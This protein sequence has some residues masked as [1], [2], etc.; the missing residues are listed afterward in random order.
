MGLREGTLLFHKLTILLRKVPLSE[1]FAIFIIFLVL[2]FP[3]QKSF[4]FTGKIFML[5]ASNPVSPPTQKCT[6][7]KTKRKFIQLPAAVPRLCK[8]EAHLRIIGKVAMS[9]LAHISFSPLSLSPF[10]LH[11]L[12]M[13]HWVVGCAQKGLNAWGLYLRMEVNS[14]ARGH[15]PRKLKQ[16]A[17]KGVPWVSKG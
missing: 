13:G 11:M 4:S 5:F 10:S 16:S 14:A 2:V 7:S 12:W 3:Q 6:M 15:W 17:Q 9:F 1:L 8:A